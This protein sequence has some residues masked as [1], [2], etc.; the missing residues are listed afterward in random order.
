VLLR[1]R[2]SEMLGYSKKIAQLRQNGEDVSE[3]ERALERGPWDV[4]AAIAEHEKHK[5]KR[6]LQDTWKGIKSKLVGAAAAPAGE[7]PKGTGNGPGDADVAREPGPHA[8]GKIVKKKKKKN[9]KAG[10]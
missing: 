10:G 7:T 5:M 1:E 2:D 9:I 6:D 4:R 3:L 8:E